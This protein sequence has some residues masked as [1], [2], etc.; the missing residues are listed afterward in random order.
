M[1]LAVVFAATLVSSSWAT[2]RTLSERVNVGECAGQGLRDSELFSATYLTP[3]RSLSSA[4]L[5]AIVGQITSA[6]LIEIHYGR[7]FKVLNE[8]HAKEQYIL[9][10]CGAA[11]PSEASINAVAALPAGF[12][13][14]F[15]TIPFQNVMVESTV[16]L[17]FLHELGLHDRVAY[18]TEYAVG[19]CWQ[20]VLGCNASGVVSGAHG[21]GGGVAADAL[22]QTRQNMDAVFMD[23]PWLQDASGE[24]EENCGGLHSIPNAI[25]FSASQD[26]APLHG[27]EHIKFMAAFF[28]KE[29]DAENLFASEVST[30]QALQAQMGATQDADKPTVAWVEVSWDG[31][32]KLSTAPFKKLMVEQA[33]AKA[34]NATAVKAAL[35]AK[36]SDAY[37]SEDKGAFLQALADSGVTALIDETYSNDVAQ[38]DFNTFLTGFGLQATSDLPFIKNSMVMRID[39]GFS[40]KSNIDWFESRLVR[41][42]TAIKGLQRVLYSDSSKAKVFFRN[43]A[44][45]EMPDAISKDSCTK[46]LAMCSAADHPAVLPII[47][48]LGDASVGGAVH[49]SSML[50]CAISALVV[51]LQ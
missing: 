24:W 26:P 30:M 12:T 36:M 17:G 8:K 25:H 29:D 41:P 15:F 50:S 45:G 3:Y 11:T 28:N 2:P 33:G 31:K 34:A 43:I 10:Q 1:R 20:K 7:S 13:R 14:K 21:S 5:D 27:A 47:H 37:V 46:N 19:A 40:G 6:D 4:A 44:K 16:Q 48:T 32:A 49:V 18:V 42:S 22:E 39:S 9:V 35:G 51:L 38:Y 23:C